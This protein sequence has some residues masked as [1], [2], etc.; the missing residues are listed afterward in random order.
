MA[1][2]VN[3]IRCKNIIFEIEDED[4]QNDIANIY[5]KEEVNELLEAFGKLNLIIVN[6][7]P[8]ENISLRSIYLLAIDK[9]HPN[10]G[11]NEYAY[12]NNKWEIIGLTRSDLTNY[13]TKE[14]INNFLSH[15]QDTL[16]IDTAL[17]DKSENL[18][19][20]KCITLEINKKVNIT[21]FLNAMELKADKSEIPTKY[22]EL[23]NDVD[24]VFDAD[25]VHTDNNYT[26][27]EKEK[28]NNIEEGA[29]VNVQADWTQKD[30]TK[31]SFIKNKPELSDVA[32]SG[33]Y[34]DLKNT[35]KALSNFENDKEFID[36]TVNN[37]TNY[38]LKADTYTKAEVNKIVKDLSSISIMKVDSLPTSNIKENVIYLVPVTSKQDDDKFDEYMYISSKW[39]RIGSAKVDL[40]NYYTKAEVNAL[41]NN[42]EPSI[43]KLGIA[44]GGT[45][46]STSK[47]AA[48]NLFQ[49]I[50]ESITDLEDTDSIVTGVVTPSA[51]TGPFKKMN[52]SYL[53]NWIKGKISSVLGLTSENYNGNAKSATSATKANQDGSG[54]VITST[55]AKKSEIPSSLPASDVKDWAKADKKPT[56]TA[57]EVGAAAS[58]HNQ[59]S[60]TI[61][62]MKGYSKPSSTSAISTS[63]TL[64]SAI[65]KLETALDEKSGGGTVTSV[66]VQATSPVVSSV[67]S[68]QTT[69]LN[70]TISLANAYGDTKNPFGSKTKSTFLGAPSN[71][72]G[73]PS[74]R[75]INASEVVG[76]V[77][78]SGN[79]TLTGDIWF[80]ND[81]IAL[82]NSFS[83]SSGGGETSVLNLGTNSEF[84]NKWSAGMWGSDYESYWKFRG[85]KIH[86]PL[87]EGTIALLSDVDNVKAKIPTDYANTIRL[88][89]ASQSTV[90]L[91]GPSG[92][93]GRVTVN[94]VTDA[95]NA[96]NDNLGN[97]IANTYAKKTECVSLKG[98]YDGSQDIIEGEYLTPLEKINI[99]SVY[100]KLVT[101]YF[102]I[103]SVSDNVYKADI[104][105]SKGEFLYSG[106]TNKGFSIE[107]KE[108]YVVDGNKFNPDGSYEKFTYPYD[109]FYKVNDDEFYYLYN[110][111]LYRVINGDFSKATSLFYNAYSCDSFF[112]NKEND[113][114]IFSEN[115][116]SYLYKLD[117]GSYVQSKNVNYRIL[118]YFKGI[119]YGINN[120]SY[121][122]IVKGP[123]FSSLKIDTNNRVSQ[124]FIFNNN[125]Y[126]FDGTQSSYL[127]VYNDTED[128]WERINAIYNSANNPSV[129]NYNDTILYLTI[130]RDIGS[131]CEYC[132][133]EKGISNIKRGDVYISKIYQSFFDKEVNIGNL[134]IGI[135]DNKSVILNTKQI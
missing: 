119:Y 45:G 84:V 31:D 26:S 2:K 128:I 61:N 86:H 55:Y 24:A 6:E 64:N 125:L 50:N 71:A 120:N 92:E 5:T 4:A 70:T 122:Y 104:D 65:G 101:K 25:Y 41:L 68:A 33:S 118:T 131:D 127:F 87:K 135:E 46:A 60:D 36:N 16:V 47:G 62:S 23:E 44:K 20:N 81:S 94:D 3:K 124:F 105:F 108:L 1:G 12:I 116:R 74:F 7:L 39:E 93:I 18:V 34:S 49:D 29:E 88:S 90:V 42:K 79:H 98:F 112:Y 97:N 132:K 83:S 69:S 103:Y 48:F 28:L 80:K 123:N 9:E 14:E 67:S 121:P 59:A 53:W 35:P 13:F 111:T 10:N 110:R 75:E 21:D 40:S 56:Y 134:I 63:D 22:S 17:S 91:S 96:T 107:S 57:S 130:N 133:I 126:R 77:S 8:K 11:Y 54:N 19:Q 72:N 129:F 76:A 37:L 114:F 109:L 52:V 73:L 38:Y 78:E 95:Q 51:T 32:L 58:S 66:R 85:N 99:N 82:Y 43:S 102:I 100:I 106:K 89:G 115:G 113:S 27:E 15:K 117:N 30:S